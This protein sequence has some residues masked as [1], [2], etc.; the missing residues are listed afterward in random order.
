MWLRDMARL[1]DD[2]RAGLKA[3]VH[4]A[5]EQVQAWNRDAENIRKM[6]GDPGLPV[7]YIDNV[8]KYMESFHKNWGFRDFPN[9]A[10]PFSAAWFEYRPP[11]SIY[12]RGRAGIM[13]TAHLAGEVDLAGF[14]EEARG[15]IHW[16]ERFF[17]YFNDVPYFVGPL[18]RLSIGVD[19][20]GAA[21][22]AYL[23]TYSDKPKAID[24]LVYPAL[25]AIAF[26]HCKNVRVVNEVVPKPL[27]KKYEHRTG[28]KPAS[29][30]VLE[31]HPLKEILR[32]E[33]RA[34]SAG[35]AHALHIC[36]GHFADYTKGAG[37]F[38]KYHVRVWI[39]DTVHGKKTGDDQKPAYD[40]RLEPEIQKL[41]RAQIDK[42]V[43][44]SK[45]N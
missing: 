24:S 34:E 33:G 42:I 43:R 22:E 45:E 35:L 18:G 7:F 39:P 17:P 27:A 41:N 25:L 23:Q 30:K 29:V 6:I 31:I 8:A 4:K 38:G 26:L 40:V 32:R 5:V 13:L 9:L 14:A 3:S 1:I 44:G 37:L 10:P 15:E 16:V 36:R 12:P 19:R 28:V 21:I 11:A 2:M 20:A